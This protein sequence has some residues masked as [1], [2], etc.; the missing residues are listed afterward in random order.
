MIYAY[1]TD[2][3][4]YTATGRAWQDKQ[5]HNIYWY[6]AKGLITQEVDSTN[7]IFGA[8]YFYRYNKKRLPVSETTN[9]PNGTEMQI[10]YYYRYDSR[11][12]WIKR[13]IK[14]DRKETQVD[15]RAISYY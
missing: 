13:I 6:N 7:G 3:N 2:S 11:G 12:N 9:Y 5:Q 15:T 1:R 4:I 10:R 8:R 14:I